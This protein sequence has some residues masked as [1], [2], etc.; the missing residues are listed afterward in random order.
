MNAHFH[1]HIQIHTYTHIYT[2]THTHTHMRVQ[3]CHL[4]TGQS[5]CPAVSVFTYTDP[6][7]ENDRGCWLTHSKNVQ[8][9]QTL[10][11]THT[12]LVMHMQPHVI[13]YGCV[14]VC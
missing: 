11:H 4:F 13:V 6:R 3:P 8:L 12:F 10:T 1:T 14:C 9:K 7:F 2:H 5:H